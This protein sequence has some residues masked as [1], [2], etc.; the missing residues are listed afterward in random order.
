MTTLVRCALLMNAVAC[1][2]LAW[3]QSTALT[4]VAILALGAGCGLPYAGVF[5]RAAALF[6]GRAGAAMGLVNMVGI[7]M[8][9]VGAPAVGRLADWSGEFRS[10]FLALGGF[11]LLATAATLAIREQA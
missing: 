3:G 10:S 4:F 8:I 7:L 5:N 11:S 6:P 9:L 1:A 2:A